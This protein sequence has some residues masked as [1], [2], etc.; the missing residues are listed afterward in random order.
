MDFARDLELIHAMETG[1]RNAVGHLYDRHA[2]AMLGVA[3][4]I[5]RDR[6]DAEDLVH[7]VFVEAWRK[8]SSFSEV[9][10][11]VRSWLLVRTRSR[12]IDRLRSLEVAR[13]HV[14]SEAAQTGDGGA[15]VP[16]ND[17]SATP[18]QRRA[19][20]ALDALPQPQREVLELAYFEGLTCSEI[21]A[22]CDAPLGTVKSRLA[23]GMRELRRVFDTSARS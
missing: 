4:R 6:R 18:D 7:D 8:A 13:R 20:A 23:A 14:R 5:L 17:P 19:R 10:G 1:D 9:R 11:S 22:R 16:A 12:A 15:A 21:A 2:P 3:S